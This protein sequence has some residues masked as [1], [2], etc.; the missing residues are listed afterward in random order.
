MICSKYLLLLFR[1]NY[2]LF[3][4]LYQFFRGYSPDIHGLNLITAMYK[5]NF[6]TGLV[7]GGKTAVGGVFDGSK[8]AVGGLF[9]GSKMAAESVVSGGSTVAGGLYRGG[10]SALGGLAKDGGAVIGAGLDAGEYVTDGLVD[11]GYYTARTALHAGQSISNKITG[12]GQSFASEIYGGDDDEFDAPMQQSCGQVQ[13]G[14]DV[15]QSEQKSSGS[16]VGRT[17]CIIAVV[18]IIAL[19]ATGKHHAVIKQIRGAAAQGIDTISSI[20]HQF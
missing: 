15:Q 2:S 17:V 10:K 16:C 8:T 18:A 12:A 11:G 20:S 13:E 6:I 3:I 1:L 9:S 19:V 5:M 4:I 14:D 7:N